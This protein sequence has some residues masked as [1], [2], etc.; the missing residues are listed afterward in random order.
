ML[1]NGFIILLIFYLGL[2]LSLTINIWAASS[3]T[4]CM[5]P[6]YKSAKL[7]AL[8]SRYHDDVDLSDC[9]TLYLPQYGSAL[10]P[11]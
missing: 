3:K 9:N 1:D 2:T 5:I 8:V 6:G 7:C 10:N 4:F 11:R